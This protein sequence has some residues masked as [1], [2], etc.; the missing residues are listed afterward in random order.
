MKDTGQSK[1][2]RPD[3]KDKSKQAS[4]RIQNRPVN[5]AGITF[6]I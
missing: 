1:A 5:A 4:V 2:Y 3:Q 6:Q